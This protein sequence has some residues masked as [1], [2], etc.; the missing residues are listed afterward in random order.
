MKRRRSSPGGGCSVTPSRLD[1]RVKQRVRKPVY[2]L[3][4]MDSLQPLK[5]QFNAHRGKPRFIAVISPTC[6]YCI[7]GASA[8][9]ASLIKGFPGA[10]ICIVWIDGV[11][12]DNFAKAK[13]RAKTIDDARFQHFHDPHRLAGK[14]IANMSGGQREDCLGYL[15]V[16]RTTVPTL[17]P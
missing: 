8:I 5:D 7:E 16:F 2:P 6:R 13:Q 17:Y 3:T 4:V 15:S 9:L 1:E 14:T 11:K 10:D 12:T